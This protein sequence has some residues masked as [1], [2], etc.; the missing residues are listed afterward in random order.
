VRASKWMK[1]FRE[2][3]LLQGSPG[4]PEPEKLTAERQAG[5]EAPVTPT[6]GASAPPRFSTEFHEIFQ[7]RRAWCPAV[8]P[9]FAR[10]M[11]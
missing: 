6:C 7:G 8:Q 9:S 1:I 10:S 11:V 2:P 3:R 4:S 5:R